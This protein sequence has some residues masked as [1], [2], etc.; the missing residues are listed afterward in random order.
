[1]AKKR[2]YRRKDDYPDLMK[3]CDDF[4]IPDK[5]FRASWPKP[6]E[7]RHFV[8]LHGVFLW[9]L[10]TLD[11][12]VKEIPFRLYFPKMDHDPVSKVFIK[13]SQ[14]NEIRHLRDKYKL[15]HYIFN[16]FSDKIHEYKYKP[17]PYKEKPTD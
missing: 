4:M 3:V 2:A 17:Y 10:R 1:M 7:S 15:H 8:I 9:K 12:K 16:L 14:D 13:M 6:T 11:T 5:Q